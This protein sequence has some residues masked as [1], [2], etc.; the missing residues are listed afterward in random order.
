MLLELLKVLELRNRKKPSMILLN[1]G[2][3]WQQISG[4]CFQINPFAF[5]GYE[6]SVVTRFRMVLFKDLVQRIDLQRNLKT[7]RSCR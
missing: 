1:R 3:K 4:C 5:T 2:S 6:I 7:Q